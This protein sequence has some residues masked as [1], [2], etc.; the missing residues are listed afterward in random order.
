M[1]S[2]PSLL[3]RLPPCD[4]VGARSL[5]LEKGQRL[6]RDQFI[7]SLAASGYRRV[8]QVQEH[9]EFAVRGALFDLFPM[10]SER[11]VRVDLFDEDIDSLRYFDPDT[12][13]SGDSVDV[14]DVLPA[15]EI[16]LDEASI[17][18]FRHGYRARFEGQPSRSRVYSDVS[19]GISHGGI[20][21][22]LPLFFDES[23]GF[24]DY[25]PQNAIIALPPDAEE[26]LQTAWAETT[27]R[28]DVCRHDP[29]RPVLPPDEAFFSADTQLARL[30]SRRT[31]QYHGHTLPDLAHHVNVPTQ[32]AP[33]VRVETRYADA[34]AALTRF[35]DGFQ[36][37]VLF[38]A[39][40][41]G[42]RETVLDFLRGRELDARRV[43]SWEEFLT[44]DHRIGVTVAPLE[45]GVVLS[46]A[47]IALIAERQLFGDRPRTDASSP[48]RPGS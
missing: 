33:A 5:H 47:G 37:R 22:Y 18:K 43:A 2:L 30:K 3:E 25:L 13:V 9:G 48:R 42:K 24:L 20:E 32:K 46:E 26:I 38:T 12:Q 31:L 28:Y 16:P 15:S 10:G 23:A 39:D 7:E 45:D 29:E 19:N 36:G 6:E 27:E 35:M 44:V 4:Y 40:S 14:V 8:P 1:L 21:Y 41:P 17:K 34:S 11:P